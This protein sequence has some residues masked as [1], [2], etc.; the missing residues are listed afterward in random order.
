M[1]PLKILFG[2]ASWHF[3]LDLTLHFNKNLSTIP[4]G[5][6]K[7]NKGVG[8]RGRGQTAEMG[9]SLWS[10][11]SSW[12]LINSIYGMK[13]T[14]LYKTRLLPA[15]FRWEQGTHPYVRW[16]AQNLKGKTLWRSCFYLVF[17]TQ[18]SVTDP[19]LH[20]LIVFLLHAALCVWMTTDVFINFNISSCNGR[21]YFS[22]T[23]CSASISSRLHFSTSSPSGRW[24]TSDVTHQ[25]HRISLHSN[26]L[27]GK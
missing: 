6:K 26:I 24:H 12:Q 16:W 21:Q 23:R 4:R 5:S 20:H 15:S 11:L 2:R 22:F 13:R 18:V 7:Q 8:L 10:W 1:C 17:G 25:M 14:S 19:H 3:T 9:L 27:K